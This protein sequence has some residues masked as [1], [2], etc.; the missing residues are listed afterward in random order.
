M[1]QDLSGNEILL[2]WE[3]LVQRLNIFING[4]GKGGEARSS[5][6]T[7]KYNIENIALKNCPSNRLCLSLFLWVFDVLANEKDDRTTTLTN[8]SALLVQ[9]K[10]GPG[11]FSVY[12]RA[13]PVPTSPP[14]IQ[15]L[16]QQNGR[17]RTSS[18]FNLS[19]TN[20]EK[21]AT[22]SPWSRAAPHS[23][24]LNLLYSRCLSAGGRYL[25]LTYDVNA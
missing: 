5:N 19:S 16:I 22:E 12:E 21:S 15:G 17:F 24:N 8:V 14:V 23:V 20:C 4:N 3:W 25:A 7:L 1:L 6:F 18:T 9:L 13:S 2:K 11:K 10:T